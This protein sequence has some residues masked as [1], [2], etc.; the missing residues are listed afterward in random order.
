MSC[1]TLASFSDIVNGVPSKPFFASKGLHQ[2]DPISPYLFIIL[3]EGLGYFLKLCARQGLIHGWKWGVGL[4]PISHLQFVDDT[5]FLG[6]ARLQ[7]AT[8]FRYALD[9]YLTAS[10]QK[11]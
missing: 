11:N 9:V 3:V 10:G 2:G 4:P 6:Q 1:V 8:S 5:S 7:E